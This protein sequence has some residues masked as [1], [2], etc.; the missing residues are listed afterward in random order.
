MKKLTVLMVFV[1]L[2]GSIA[3]QQNEKKASEILKKVT[4]KTKSYTSIKIDFVYSLENKEANVKESKNG[5]LLIKGDKYN[6]KLAGQTVISN[7]KT[8]WTYIPDAGEVQINSIEDGD[9]SLTPTKLLTSYYKEYKSK[10]M[11]ETTK[12]GKNVQ[13]IDCVPLEGKSF[14]K[15]RLIIDK[16]NLQIAE[17][18]IYDK[19][20]S[21][22][23]YSIKSFITNTTIADTK[24][25]FKKSDYPS[26]VEIV[27]MR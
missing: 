13:I 25:L 21:V 15:V 6:L 23:T 2:V 22:Y 26:D 3:A 19:N 7:S 12:N 4:E 24:F 14:F 5:I 17:I 11:K 18:A 8:I 1:M 16:K 9:E 10:L 27:D 20:G